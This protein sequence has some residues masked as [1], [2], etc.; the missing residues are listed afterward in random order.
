[1]K[2]WLKRIILSAGTAIA[3]G[4]LIF[5]PN[6]LAAGQEKK[7]GTETAEAPLLSVRTA[8]AEKRT[9]SAFLELNGDIVSA[10]EADA[11][12]DV[13]GKLIQVNVVLGTWVRKGDVIALIDPSRPGAVYMNSPVHAPLSGIVSEVPVSAGMI[14]SPNTPITTVSAID[15]LEITAR[16]PEREVACLKNGLKAD[17]TLQ[18]YPGE[19]F[20]A[21]ISRVAPILDSATRTK[22]IVFAFD[23]HD[24]R[25]NAGMFA[26]IRLNTKTYENILVVPAEALISKRGESIV[27][28]LRDGMSGPPLAELRKVTVGVSL[29]G[30]TEIKSGLSEGE[31]VVVQGQQLLSGGEPVRSIGGSR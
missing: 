11:F 1:M 10:R 25:I 18:A 6:F 24:S 26:R 3:A 27:F 7:G 9:L 16:I 19:I 31:A 23:Q 17:V 29:N 14:V 22:L 20:S 4:L 8:M 30:W 28:I 2:N 13:S 5:G 12:P 21:A 15:N